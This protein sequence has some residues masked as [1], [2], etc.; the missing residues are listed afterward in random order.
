MAELFKAAGKSY[1]FDTE[2]AGT[3]DIRLDKVTFLN[4]LRTVLR[5]NTPTLAIDFKDSV[6]HVRLAHAASASAGSSFQG[7]PDDG[8]DKQL[9]KL[10][11]DNLLAS[12]L[13]ARL[14][15]AY[16]SAIPRNDVV[17]VDGGNCLMIYAGAEEFARIH[18]IV[19]SLDVL[20]SL[21]KSA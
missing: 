14:T 12:Q 9:Y 11:I 19:S 8:A 4:A 20:P 13:L 17:T 7:S 5:A 2:V 10:P 3:V 6:Y 15:S 18:D 16:A 21:R 1:I